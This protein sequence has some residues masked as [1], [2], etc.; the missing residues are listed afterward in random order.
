M[1][2]HNK[3]GYLLENFRLFHLRSETGEQVDFHYHEFCKILLL[4]SGQGS[5]YVEGQRYSLIPGDIVLI[6]SRSVHKPELEAG[7]PYERIIIYISPDYLQQ[8]SAEDAD[9]LS[10]FDGKRGHVLRPVESRRRKLFGIAAALEE[11]L[12][13]PGFGQE[14]LSRCE[15]ARLVVEIGRSFR[16]KR[17][18]LPS[19]ILPGNKRI[20]EI[21]EYLDG[22]LSEDIDMDALAERFYISK[23][24]M[25]RL[26][27]RETGETVYGYLTQKRLLRSRQLM[28]GGMSAT[29]ACYACGFHS[30][31]SFTRAYGKYFGTTPTGRVDASLVREEAAE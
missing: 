6:G 11:N 17:S 28:D 14:I 2:N 30:Y 21:M 25:M 22:N 31:S 3:R 4:V 7:V 18:D 27:R 26:F 13:K 5:Y 20:L 23:Y 1:A 29:Q 24:H 16:D 19:P 12:S 15:L 10:V 9:L 8:I